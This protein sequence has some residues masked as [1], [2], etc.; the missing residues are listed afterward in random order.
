M[1][2]VNV[3]NRTELS[4][5]DLPSEAPVNCAGKGKNFV[6][7]KL[8]EQHK[9]VQETE[10]YLKTSVFRCNSSICKQPQ[11]G[12][13]NVDDVSLARKENVLKRKR[14]EQL[15]EKRADKAKS[16]EGY[17]R[18]SNPFKL[19]GH[20]G[21]PENPIETNVCLSEAYF[22]IS[23]DEKLA[24]AMNFPVGLNSVEFTEWVHSKTESDCMRF[25]LEV[26]KVRKNMPSSGKRRKS[27]SSKQRKCKKNT[28]R[29]FG[30][31][32]H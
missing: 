13:V 18:P 32:Y 2:G 24:A 26:A 3:I 25:L 12:S 15:I 10:H 17:L 7:Q 11:V 16:L 14:E 30:Y 6:L 27:Q 9:A 5:L 8:K 21:N 28:C 31:R 22:Q 20:V 1:D 23:A 4:S 29:T 19:T